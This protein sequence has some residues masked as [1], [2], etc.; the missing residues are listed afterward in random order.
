ML[1]GCPDFGHKK[2]M[3]KKSKT[4]LIAMEIVQ[5]KMKK[6][7]E[8]KSVAIYSALSLLEQQEVTVCLIAKFPCFLFK[9]VS[10]LFGTFLCTL[11]F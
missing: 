9:K 1:N 8:Q 10:F 7:G 6:L 5:Q 4:I 2:G 3:I 11:F